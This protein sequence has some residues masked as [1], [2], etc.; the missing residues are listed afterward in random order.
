MDADHHSCHRDERRRL[1]RKLKAAAQAF[2]A[3]GQQGYGQCAGVRGAPVRPADTNRGHSGRRSVRGCTCT[4]ANKTMRVRL[5]TLLT[6][7]FHETAP[8]HI[9][10]WSM[11]LARTLGECAARTLV[12]CAKT[13]E[14]NASG[15][16]SSNEGGVTRAGGGARLRR[17][18][19]ERDAHSS[20]RRRHKRTTSEVRGGRLHSMS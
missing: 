6:G 10:G 8:G 9:A 20:T 1:L 2:R 19:R 17:P 13:D 12:A 4:R 7:T 18:R 15:A 16:L 3:C 5:R 11:I 14:T